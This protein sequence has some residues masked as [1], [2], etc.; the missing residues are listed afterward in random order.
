MIMSVP[1]SLKEISEKQKAQIDSLNLE[2]TNH[3]D[4]RDEQINGIF[5]QN[6]QL[7]QISFAILGA[8]LGLNPEFINRPFIFTGSLLIVANATIF[9]LI[10]Q[11]FQRHLNAQNWQETS[12][13]LHINFQPVQKSYKDFV[14]SFDEP[15]ANQVKSQYLFDEYQKEYFKFQDWYSEQARFAK[16]AKSTIFAIG[17][18][19][20]LHFV[21]GIL[22][23]A[24]G[25]AF[26]QMSSRKW[27]ILFVSVSI[28]IGISLVLV[29]RNI[30]S[31]FEKS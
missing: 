16:F 1:L 28:F 26:D 9:G 5:D 8:V 13:A 6:S 10:A 31:R 19:Y 17:I 29:M 3:I 22:L 15:D 11:Y 23:I 24:L 14:I 2:K 27:D 7:A 4:K 25:L 12:L 20:Y 18:W 30:I 21:N